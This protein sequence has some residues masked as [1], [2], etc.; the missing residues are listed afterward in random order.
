MA[1]VR[2][3]GTPD[4][5]A[6]KAH[7]VKSPLQEL[8]GVAD[9]ED[10]FARQPEFE[11]R[12]QTPPPRLPAGEPAGQETVTMKAIG[13]LLRQEMAPMKQ[14][15][16]NLEN[17]VGE[18]RETV[19]KR[20]KELEARMDMTDIRV[21]KLE[22]ISE[23][24]ANPPGVD[25]ITEQVHDLERQIAALK[26]E[27]GVKREGGEDRVHTAVI[28]GLQGLANFEES[29]TWVRD[30]L[31]SL[32]APPPAEVFK[33]RGDFKGVI[34]AKFATRSDRDEAVKLLKKEG[35]KEHGRDVWAK[36]SLPIETRAPRT[37]L[38]GLKYLLKGWDIHAKVDEGMTQL[39]VGVEKVLSVSISGNK[40]NI[41]WEEAW[42]AWEELV[43]YQEV[44]DL[45]AKSTTMLER[46]NGK[47]KGKG[48]A[49][50]RGSGE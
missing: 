16:T 32:Y 10:S 12:P 47:A 5:G 13:D 37:L 20:L 36:E 41:E 17:K 11:V 38:L 25:R 27:P 44:K 19:D 28:G 31:W 33:G 8:D 50:G 9:E 14:S 43:N 2:N 40:L 1:L 24:L 23:K 15:M 34:F 21:A 48:P 4:G 18:L 39:T 7:R 46:A 3:I 29:E 35:L 49:K 30:K 22:S 42:G 6:K 45:I 26:I